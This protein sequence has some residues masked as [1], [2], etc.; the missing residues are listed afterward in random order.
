VL[1]EE[2]RDSYEALRVYLVIGLNSVWVPSEIIVVQLCC[3]VYC[4]CMYVRLSHLIGSSGIM[5]AELQ[6][7][8]LLPPLSLPPLSVER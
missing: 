6:L 5:S 1:V 4:V 2:T 8:S 7:S 3:I